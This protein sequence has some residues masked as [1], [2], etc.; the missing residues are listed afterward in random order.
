MVPKPLI[1]ANW[2]TNKTVPEALEWLKEL[3]NKVKAEKNKLRKV[4]VV[5]CPPFI[6]LESMR[7]K[8]EDWQLEIGLG[9]Q[10]VSPFP[11][12]PYTGEI[13]ARMLA[14]LVD[15]VLIG[16]SER[17]KDFGENIKTAGQK[18]KMAQKAGITPILCVAALEEIPK[19]AT[20]NFYL[21]YEPPTAISQKGVYRPESPGNAQKTLAKWKSRVS[22]V[23]KFLYGGSVNPANI[24]QLLAQPDINGVVVGHASLDPNVFW[25]LVNHVL[26]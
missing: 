10:D 3:Q 19:K 22:N 18:I 23:D 21:L 1:V 12:G 5:V 25:E 9:A 16:H 8:I 6:A 11:D 7:L 4:E 17:E 14:N 20:G 2:K 26:P 13:S 15:Y 24:A